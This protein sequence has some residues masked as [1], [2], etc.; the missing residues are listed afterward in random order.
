MGAGGIVLAAAMDGPGGEH[1]LVAHQHDA[2]LDLGRMRLELF[3]RATAGADHL[4]GGAAGGRRV[5][6][7]ATGPPKEGSLRA[8][9]AVGN[10]DRV[11]RIP[12]RRRP[13]ALAQQREGA[14]F[15]AG[16]G[17]PPD[18]I[19]EKIA[20]S[21]GRATRPRLPKPSADRGSTS[22]H[23][24]PAATSPH[25]LAMNSASTTVLSCAPAEANAAIS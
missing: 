17:E 4:G 8:P 2:A 1:Q 12:R 6:R 3:R 14:L 7:T 10:G 5:G 22:A 15:A 25:R 23:P 11:P 20:G 21:N 13:H 9:A 19:A 16:A 18:A 24:V